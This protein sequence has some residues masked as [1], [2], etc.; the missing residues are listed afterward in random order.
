MTV[1]FGNSG[2]MKWTLS[3]IS[4]AKD[5]FRCSNNV[6]RSVR[7][8][9]LGFYRIHRGDFLNEKFSDNGTANGD[10]K[11]RAPAGHD[12]TQAQQ[13]IHNEASME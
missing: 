8:E 12:F 10:L 4:A 5:I 6:L 2:S 13:L 1:A 7:P 9:C 11:S 3:V